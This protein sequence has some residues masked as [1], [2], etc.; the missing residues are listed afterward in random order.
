MT[1]SPDYARTRRRIYRRCR[2]ARTRT[3]EP[4]GREARASA[5]G[6]DVTSSVSAKTA[7]VVANDPASTTAKAQ[8]AREL[9]TWMVDE[10][11]FLCLLE[12]VCPGTL[13][14]ENRPSGAGERPAVPVTKPPGPPGPLSGE[15]VLLLGDVADAE[16]LAAQIEGAGGVTTHR[17]SKGVTLVVTGADP[18]PHRLEAAIGYGAIVISAE[19][20]PARLEA[21]PTAKAA[22]SPSP[23]QV[24]VTS[25]GM[26][27]LTVTTAEPSTPELSLPPAGWHADPY[28]RYPW[29]YWD[30]RLWT[31]Y[32]SVD[33]QT[34][35]DSV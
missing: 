35:T 5:S 18:D 4:D 29:R 15:R 28:Q 13:R 8:S 17:V 7:L 25:D 20:L 26:A 14:K 24:E 12:D 19:G 27:N 2:R 16:A 23:I 21:G 10:A 1:R 6:L 32:V 31:G 9:G 3:R 30:G 34:Y 22:E 11:T 33:G